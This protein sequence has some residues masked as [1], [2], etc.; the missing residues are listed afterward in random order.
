VVDRPTSTWSPPPGID[1]AELVAAGGFAVVYRGWQPDFHRQVAVK[2]LNADT[3][4][5]DVRARFDREVRAMG[6]LSD[7]PNVVP[8]YDAGV[9]DDRPYLVMP[10]LAGGTLADEMRRDRLDPAE[11]VRVGRA[12]AD[13]LD[14]A[15]RAG[16]LHRD[17]KP[18]NILRTSYGEPKL[19]DFG[20]ARFGDSTATHGNIAL[21]VAYAAPELLRGE[22]ASVAS[23]VYSLGATL[24]A[25]LRGAPPFEVPDGGAPIAMAMRIVEEDPPGLGAAG[26]PRPLAAVVERAMAKDPKARFPSAAALRDALDGLDLAA[27]DDDA[28]VAIAAAPAAAT[29]VAPI[30]DVREPAPEP[31]REPVASPAPPRRSATRSWAPLVVALLAIG[32]VAVALLAGLGDDDEPPATTTTT[33][34]PATSEAAPSST[35]TPSTSEAAQSTTTPT[36]AATT[37]TTTPPP[38]DAAGDPVDAARDYFAVL[39]A[40]DI[41]GGWAR[42]SPR[43]QEESGRDAYYGFWSTIDSVEVLDAR[44]GDDDRSAVVQLL[45]TRDDGSTATQTNTLRFVDS[46]RGL[47]VDGSS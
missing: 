11:V 18:A 39:D 7:H 15:H 47:L 23:D 20:I 1:G 40:G 8:V 16:L 30:V 36:T 41:D 14:A 44:P 2:V 26:V 28:T 42:L 33:S 46:D 19:G 24:H 38:S 3:R 27:P 29:T 45:Y 31:V 10:Y 12:V 21:T 43:Y 5:P 4:D 13:A 35:S 32:V 6:S 22:P 17:V 9:H 25:L 34:T 37:P